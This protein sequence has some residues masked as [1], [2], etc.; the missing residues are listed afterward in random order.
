[1]DVPVLVRRAML[2]GLV[3]LA[4]LGLAA[5]WPAASTTT[6][7]AE[8]QLRVQNVSP[9]P[10]SL[11][12]ATALPAPP[13]LITPTALAVAPP[14]GPQQI[15]IDA[16][17]A[18][19]L[20]GN[21]VQLAGRTQRM[22]TSGQLGY[23]V[24]DPGSQVIGSG[25]VPVSPDAGGGGAFNAPLAFRLLQN[26]GNITARLFEITAD[27]SQVA[28]TD[29]VMSVQSQVQQI[30]IDTPPAGTQVGS[31]M[32]LTGRVARPPNQGLL[33]YLVTNSSQ[34]QIGAGTFPVSGDP[35]RPMSY[36]GSLE[37]VL[38]FDGDTITTKIYDQDQANGASVSLFVAPVP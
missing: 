20:V 26:G 5:C 36:V 19:M 21:P 28:T 13:Q 29:L 17:P 3:A 25:N 23:Q 16:P 7:T 18:G 37:F 22:P 30:F 1:M 12:A 2:L 34:Q 38:P 6:P 11:A 24:L 8:S 33:S 14:L 27:G 32:T 4:A 15:F 31:P 35:G 10:A 9:A